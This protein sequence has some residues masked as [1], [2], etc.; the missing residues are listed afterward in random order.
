MYNNSYIAHYGV[1]GM[2][3]G[4]HRAIGRYNSNKQKATRLDFKSES[5]IRVEQER[6]KK[7]A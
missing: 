2:K 7:W 1:L 3:W 5:Q 6:W 4:I